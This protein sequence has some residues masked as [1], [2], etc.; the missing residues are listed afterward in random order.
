MAGPIIEEKPSLAIT[1]VYPASCEKVY[2]AWTDPKALSRWFAPSDQFADPEVAADVRVGGRYRIVMQAPD[3]E[4]HRVG[5]VYREVV[6]LRKLVFTWAWES[7]PERESLVTLEFR[8]SGN[9][10]ELV[11]RHERFADVTARD[12]HH[13]GWDACLARLPNALT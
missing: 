2:Q 9:A 10:T 13:Q 4:M 1:R 5:G 7:T 11:L 12:K 3:G 8:P 6:P